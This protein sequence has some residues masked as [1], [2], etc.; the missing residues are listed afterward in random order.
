[1]HQAS[2][3]LTS[4]ASHSLK[5]SVT[6]FADHYFPTFEDKKKKYFFVSW[7]IKNCANF[8]YVIQYNGGVNVVNVCWIG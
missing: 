6:H 5:K 7:Y 3:F 1:M 4:R 2:I 8:V